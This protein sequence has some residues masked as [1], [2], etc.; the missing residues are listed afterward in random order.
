MSADEQRTEPDAPAATPEPEIEDKHKQQAE[1]MAETYEDHR[2]HTI[3]PGTDGMIAGTAVADWVDESERG[4]RD[5]PP[6]DDYEPVRE[7]HG[8]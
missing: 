4:Q 8:K 7:Q 1:Q 2:P 6:P 5:N 3:L